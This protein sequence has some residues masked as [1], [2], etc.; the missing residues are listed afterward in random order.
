MQQV[1][2]TASV[3]TPSNIQTSLS[4]EKIEAQVLQDQK[5]L[6]AGVKANQNAGSDEAIANAAA[7]SSLLGLSAA[8]GSFPT[9]TVSTMTPD[10]AVRKRRRKDS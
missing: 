8:V 6:A 7:V 3:N 2:T 1:D 4:L 5:D 10:R 9:L